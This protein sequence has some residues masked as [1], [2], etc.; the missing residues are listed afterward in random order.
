MK[1]PMK[2]AAT[3][4]VIAAL[5][6][7]L[8]IGVPSMCAAATF[9]Y[10]SDADDATIDAYVMDR[11]TGG[12]TSIGKAEAGKIVMPMAIA[13]DKKFLYAVAWYHTP[14]A[15]ARLPASTR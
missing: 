12:L 2:A 10:V 9:V 5:A 8:T 14:L 1:T 13:P 6:A 11:K 4:A 7:L 3:V 15:I